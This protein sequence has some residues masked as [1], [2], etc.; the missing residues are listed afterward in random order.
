MGEI[1]CIF[2]VG[3]PRSGTT[4][5]QSSVMCDNNVYFIPETHLFTKGV[6]LGRLPEFLTNRWT[7]W[8][9]YQ[10][11]KRCFTEEHIFY[12]TSKTKLVRSFFA[13]LENKAREN[14]KS[15]ILE[16][17]PGHLNHIDYISS[18]FT[19]AQFVHVMRIYKGAIPS[20]LKATKQW[21]G[22]DNLLFNMRRCISEI[23]ASISY[24]NEFKHYVLIDFDEMI[25]VRKRLVEKLNLELGLEIEGVTDEKLAEI[26]QSIIDPAETC[27]KNNL[28]GS[29]VD[30]EPVLTMVNAIKKFVDYMNRSSA[31]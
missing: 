29:R 14:D 1:K 24:T 30:H 16:K 4:L 26:S 25:S 7:T 3:F 31:E 21:G 15:I 9:Y 13:F 5:A 10:W 20:K 17:T 11:V 12:S 23:F 18:I 27:K 8:Y 2:M 22:N 6:K 19:N 28:R